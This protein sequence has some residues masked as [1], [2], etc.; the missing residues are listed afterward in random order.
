MGQLDAVLHALSKGKSVRRDE[1]EPCVR[2][3]VTNDILMCQCGNAKPW[4]HALTWGE[5]SASDWES[6]RS[7]PATWSANRAATT[8]LSTQRGS[9]IDLPSSF[10]DAGVSHN[11]FLRW[12]FPNRRGL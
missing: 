12:F 11:S 6:I 8:P 10:N 7:A 3:F 5:I 4:R 1:W 2:M 9:D